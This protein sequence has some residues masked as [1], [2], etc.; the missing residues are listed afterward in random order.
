M[1]SAFKVDVQGIT[2][3]TSQQ[4]QNS[5]YFGHVDAT[6]VSESVEYYEAVADYAIGTIAPVVRLAILNTAQLTSVRVNIVN[7]FGKVVGPFFLEKAIE[8]PIS[9]LVGSESDGDNMVGVI[10][11]SMVPWLGAG[12]RTLKRSNVRI[13]PIGSDGVTSAQ[14]IVGTTLTQLQQTAILISDFQI[15]D[16]DLVQVRMGTENAEGE[17]G[18][19][20]VRG[21]VVRPNAS[22]LG[23]RKRKPRG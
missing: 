19:A 20:L 11:F 18:T 13:G 7:Q 23:S 10:A 4:I 5:F 3:G 12:T 15:P 8:T 17:G 2:G 21:C 1:A 6:D 14:R 22:W 16:F 9:G